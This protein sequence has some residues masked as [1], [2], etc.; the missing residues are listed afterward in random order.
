MFRSLPIAA[1]IAAS[2]AFTTPVLAASDLALELKQLARAQQGKP[3]SALKGVSYND[4]IKLM[5]EL[6]YSDYRGLSQ[7]MANGRLKLTRS[8]RHALELKAPRLN[9]RGPG[10]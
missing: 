3:S 8:I 4:A 6:N 1:A 9:Q 2:L 10:R 7:G 5:D